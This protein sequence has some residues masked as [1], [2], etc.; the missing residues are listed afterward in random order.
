MVLQA[1]SLAALIVAARRY[2]TDGDALAV[3]VQVLAGPSKGGL[4][5]KA[6]V[7][8]NSL[9]LLRMLEGG[10]MMGLHGVCAKSFCAARRLALLAQQGL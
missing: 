1:S 7:A 2:S 8:I 9:E 5:N 4:A 6:A 3:A 10:N